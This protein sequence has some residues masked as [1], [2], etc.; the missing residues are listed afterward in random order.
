MVAV[1]GQGNT[2]GISIQATPVLSLG[3][4]PSVQLTGPYTLSSTDDGTYFY[5]STTVTVTI[6]AGLNPMPQCVFAPPQSGSIT[7]HPT[8]GAQINGATSDVAISIVTNPVP[9]GL[10]RTSVTDNY[11]VTVA[12][13]TFA[14]LT[15]DPKNNAIL[16][17]YLAAL[18]PAAPGANKLS[19]AYTLA[20]TDSGSLIW[21]NAQ[22]ADKIITIPST[23]LNGSPFWCVIGYLNNGSNAGRCNIKPGGGTSINTTIAQSTGASATL[24]NGIFMGTASV[25]NTAA[26]LVMSSGASPGGGCFIWPICGTFALS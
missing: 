8:G 17:G 21:L 25:A 18:A 26:C 7:L 16:A 2:P 10:V 9:A 20:A 6:P 22:A 5:A 19:A 3:G 24:T 4:A 13:A 11:G 14:G 12:G 23:I 15:D 1:T